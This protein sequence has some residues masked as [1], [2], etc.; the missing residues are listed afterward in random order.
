MALLVAMIFLKTVYE[1]LLN[2][3][4]LL[5]PETGGI[6][7]GQR[8]IITEVYFDKQNDLLTAPSIY[9]PNIN[10][11]NQIIADWDKKNVDFC[12]IF[13]THYSHDQ[14]ISLG[15]RRYIKK[16][17]CAMPLQIR[18]LYFPIILPQKT[19]IGYRASRCKS[20]VHIACDKIEILHSGG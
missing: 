17:M 19:I 9:I 1:S 13:H 11:I 12:G 10:V 18:Y 6:I 2:K 15:D 5:P 3:T 20:N 7:G 4:P 16:I 14:E 8:G